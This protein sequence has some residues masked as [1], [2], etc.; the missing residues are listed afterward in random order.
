MASGGR[1]AVT[2]ALRSMFTRDFLYL[3]VSALQ[4]IL[5]SAVTPI[6][7]RRVGAGQFGQLA[8]AI[9]VMQILGPVFSFGLPFSVQKVFAGEN[10]DRRARGVLAASAVL[11]AAGWFAVVLAVPAWGPAVGIDRGLD[12]RLAASWG[13]SFALT[14]TALAMLRSRDNLG[15][16]IFIGALQALG[17]QGA[18]LALLY[19]WAPTITSYLWGAAVVQGVAALTGLLALRPDWPALAAIRRTGRAL[20]FGL[21]MV[22]QQLS[23]FILF[24]GDRI[25]VRHDMGSAA[26]GRYS[27]AYN[28]GSLG[29]VLLVFVNQAWLPRIL[30]VPDRASR[31]RLLA[32]S[33]D[34]MDLLLVPVVCGL[35]AGAPVVLR[36]WAPPSFNPGGLAM[37][38]AIV[39]LCTFPYG[40]FLSNLRAL[41][42]EGKTGR[43]AVMT[44]V[45]AAVN[46]GLNIAMVPFFGITGSAVATVLSYLLL[47]RLTRPPVS[48]GLR[49]PGVSA[50]LGTII[51]CAVAA[52]LALAA[53]PTSAAVAFALLVRRA[54]S[55]FRTSSSY[56]PR[57]R[58]GRRAGN[59]PAG[60]ALP[61]T[62]ASQR[63]KYR[64]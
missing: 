43:A 60:A 24:A 41:M 32:S 33:R 51:G 19:L 53:L 25:V 47:A 42:S 64:T 39:A 59:T 46:V 15:M 10:G 17:A 36:I 55:G 11:G 44:L 6:L 20:L 23:A 57:H 62:H 50:V 2:D 26:T 18:G 56:V 37:I 12:A 63:I 9:A 3:A 27:V 30:A 8:L 48:S 35:A 16:V 14:W 38:A 28:V 61:L 5:S 49:V 1:Q 21:P 29:V 4:V 52:S 13:A 22:A 58:R 34:V 31:S 54:P 40:Q 7:T 45:A